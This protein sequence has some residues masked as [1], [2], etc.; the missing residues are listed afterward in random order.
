M[1]GPVSDYENRKTRGYQGGR[2]SKKGGSHVRDTQKLCFKLSIQAFAFQRAR[3]FFD[4]V[5]PNYR[6]RIDF[7]YLPMEF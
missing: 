3:V 4:P 1:A 2:R 6:E 5:Y 7:M